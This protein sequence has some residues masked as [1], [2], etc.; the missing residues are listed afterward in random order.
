MTGNSEVVRIASGVESEDLVFLVGGEVRACGADEKSLRRVREHLGNLLSLKTF[1]VLLGSGASQHLHA[2]LIREMSVEGVAAMITANRP[3]DP[4]TENE[5]DLVKTL[6]GQQAIDLEEMLNTLN[7]TINITRATAGSI[8][9]GDKPFDLSVLSSLRKKLNRGLAAACDLRAHAATLNEPLKSDPWAVHSSFF[10]KLLYARREL[11][12]THVFTTNYD[13]AIE[14]A[15]DGAG[16]DYIDGFKGTVE[17]RFHPETYGQALYYK[18]ASEQRHLRPVSG[19]L[20]LYKLHG[21]INW[22]FETEA[23]RT[24][25]IVQRHVGVEDNDDLAVIYPTQDKEMDTLGYPYAD[26]FRALGD[27]AQSSD[28]G[29]VCI[30]YG[31]HDRHLNR[32]LETAFAANYSLQMLAVDPVGIFKSYDAGSKTAVFKDGALATLMSHRDARFSGLTGKA[33]TFA[34]FSETLLPDVEHDEEPA[35]SEAGDPEIK[36]AL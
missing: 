23:S 5:T 35:G 6:S 16:F 29:I 4:L 10:R 19:S 2:P 26:L 28:V 34:S 1:V 30:G 31:F 24:R 3:Q 8:T 9:V 33:A 18:P 21:S 15:L 12:A 36:L 11:P 14:Y 25:S 27:V 13:L 22:R 17:R 32:I 20:Y 7:S